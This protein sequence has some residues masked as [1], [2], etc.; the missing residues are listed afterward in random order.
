MKRI[1]LYY[2]FSFSFGG[3]EHLPL[4]FIATLLE[5]GNLTVA[6][7]VASNLGR[8]A[9]TFGV[10]IDLSRLDVVQVTPPGYSI[11]KHRLADSLYRS[12]R[13]KRLAREADVC[14]SAANIMDFGKPAHHFI[15]MLAFG[16]SAFTAYAFRRAAPV[17]MGLAPQVKRFVSE[18]LIRPVLGMRSKRGIIQDRRERIYPNSH[19]VKRVMEDFYGP[20]SGEVFYPPTRFEPCHATVPRDPLKVVCIGR[21]VPEKRIEDLVDIVGKARA[22]TGLDITFQVA[23]R[24]D[25]TPAYGRMLAGMAAERS[26]LEFTGPL[27]GEEKEQFLL[28]GSYALHA[29][30]QEA[31]GISV[32]EY[33]KAGLVAIVPDEGGAPEVVGSPELAYGTR[34]GAAGIL[35][36]LLLDAAFREKMRCHCA[37]RSKFFSCEAYLARQRDLLERIVNGDA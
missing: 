25:Q 27:Y 13:L 15:N 10:D 5:A 12:R 24:L 31:F 21:I 4:S 3:G 22:A 9:K 20:F 34:D 16:D 18:A 30:R 11:K 28:S 33:L 23:G 29:E 37:G 17:R 8:A 36:R 1:L 14:I 32:A 2:P 7:D 19:F 26:W 35:S 6:L